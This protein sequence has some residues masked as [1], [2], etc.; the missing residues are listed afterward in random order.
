MRD[1]FLAQ[2]PEALAVLRDGNFQAQ[3]VGR[4]ETGLSLGDVTQSA[5]NWPA[6][7]NR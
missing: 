5:V 1:T 7:T 3:L 6:L 2:I 4:V